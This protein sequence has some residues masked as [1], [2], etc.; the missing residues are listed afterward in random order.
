MAAASEQDLGKA[1]YGAV[2]QRDIAGYGAS[3]RV[4][5]CMTH[6]VLL[7]YWTSTTIDIEHKPLSLCLCSM[8]A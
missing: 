7:C 8:T 4:G 3:A 5:R 2:P 6:I 1:V